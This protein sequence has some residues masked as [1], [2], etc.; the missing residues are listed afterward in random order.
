[1]FHLPSPSWKLPKDTARRQKCGE[2]T[3]WTGYGTDHSILTLG[4]LCQ[5]LR[6]GR[7]VQGD[8][9]SCGT[10]AKPVSKLSC[11][12][13]LL[14]TI[15]EWPA[16]SF[17]ISLPIV[18]GAQFPISPRKLQQCLFLTDVELGAKQIHLVTLFLGVISCMTISCVLKVSAP[19]RMLP[20]FQ[21][22]RPNPFCCTHSGVCPRLSSGLSNRS[23]AKTT[24]CH[25]LLPGPVS[26]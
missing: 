22:P 5:L 17:S 16:S 19:L 12:L 14:P 1:M 21:G 18:Y 7:P 11:L 3:L 8:Y 6:C 13:N 25:L 24:D 9:L 10:L 20:V 4:P 26:P 23:D 15:P 2:A